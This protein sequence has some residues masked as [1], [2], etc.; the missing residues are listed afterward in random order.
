[1]VPPASTKPIAPA[2]GG[3]VAGDRP[4][5]RHRDDRPVDRQGHRA[6]VD[7][8]GGLPAAPRPEAARRP[9]LRRL[10]RPRPALVPGRHADRLHP[11]RPVRHQQADVCQ[12]AAGCP[13][14]R[15]R[16]S[17]SSMPTAGTSTASPRAASSRTGRR[18]ARGSSSSHRPTASPSPIRAR[19]PGTPSRARSSDI[20]TVRPDGT[21][22]RPVTS[23]QALELAELDRRRTDLVRADMSPRTTSVQLW[24]MD[25]DGTNATQV[26]LPPQLLEQLLWNPSGRPPKP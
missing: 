3:G 1:M 24:I 6:G 21:D 13:T 12:R 16:R 20:S 14:G 5:D 7:D 26:S 18:M 22:Q 23:D 17:S 4:G 9:Q 15:G 19:A 25:A 8:D 11:G 2:F 10:R